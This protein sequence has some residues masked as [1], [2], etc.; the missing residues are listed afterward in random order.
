MDGQSPG[1]VAWAIAVTKKNQ[2][3][4]KQSKKIQPASKAKAPKPSDE[5][6]PEELDKVT[7][8]TL[9]LSLAARELSGPGGPSAGALSPYI[10]LLA[11]AKNVVK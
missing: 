5:L 7:G 4:G 1:V 11:V 3:A 8:G 10:P 2:K 6:E 9:D